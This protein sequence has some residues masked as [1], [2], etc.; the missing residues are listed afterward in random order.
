MGPDNIADKCLVRFVDF[1]RHARRSLQY[2]L[3][4]VRLR[5][6][7]LKT[8]SH[9]VASSDLARKEFGTPPGFGREPVSSP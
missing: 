4:K 5:N 2:T 1:H 6:P 3:V 7:Q 9:E 8:K